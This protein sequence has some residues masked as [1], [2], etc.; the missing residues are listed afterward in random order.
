[1]AAAGM[2]SVVYLPGLVEAKEKVL[3]GDRSRIVEYDRYA[4]GYDR[5]ETSFFA[6]TFGLA[7]LRAEALGLARGDVLELAVGTGLNLAFYR[8]DQVSSFR[9]VDLSRE[10][11]QQARQRDAFRILNATLEVADATTLPFSDGTFDTVVDTYSLCTFDDPVTALKEA[12]RVCRPN[13]T[14]ILVEHVV[15]DN[16]ALSAYQN[17][18]ADA[19]KKTSKGCAWNQNL[20]DLLRQA[21]LHIVC[22]DRFVLGTVAFVVATP[23]IPM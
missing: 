3:G 9:G 20:N 10:M 21:G 12:R 23:S 11:L 13:G 19:V 7:K 1:M 2:G 16:R 15:S 18:T 14:V 6:S 5:L 4:A 22:E 8:P 17:L